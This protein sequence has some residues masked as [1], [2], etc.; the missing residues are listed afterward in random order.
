[1]KPQL[2]TTDAELEALIQLLHQKPRGLLF[3]RDEL[4]GWILGMNIYKH[5]RVNDRQHWLS[6]W[7]GADIL[8][9]RKTRKKD[10]AGVCDAAPYRIVNG[11]VPL[12]RQGN[13]RFPSSARHS[14]SITSVQP[15]W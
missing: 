9:N 4:A 13:H 8:V 7:N 6:L 14:K 15:G 2:Y 11:L 10:A 3:V 5:S 12:S 1:M